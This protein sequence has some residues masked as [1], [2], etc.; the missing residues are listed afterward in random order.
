[1]IE[2]T[3]EAVNEALIEFRKNIDENRYT[4]TENKMNYLYQSIC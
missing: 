4:K 2:V 3:K 1:M